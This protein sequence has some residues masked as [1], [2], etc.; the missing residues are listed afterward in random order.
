VVITAEETKY[1][2]GDLGEILVILLPVIDSNE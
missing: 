2:V 1:A